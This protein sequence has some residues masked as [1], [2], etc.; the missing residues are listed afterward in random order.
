VRAFTLCIAKCDI[1][2]AHENAIVCIKMAF[3]ID[4]R[5][6]R[7]RLKH[8][9]HCCAA[10]DWSPEYRAWNDAKKRCRD[11]PLYRAKGIR[12]CDRWLYGDGD[13]TGF[14]CFVADMGAKPSPDHT[15]DRFP[16]NDGD[17]SPTNTRWATRSEQAWSHRGKTASAE[18]RA[19]QS[20]AHKG[21]KLSAETRAKISAAERRPPR[22]GKVRLVPGNPKWTLS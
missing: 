19:K 6:N 22:K 13:L 7:R 1:N 16:D 9:I 2:P 15:L 20:A 14:Q 17:Y 10:G 12:V 8:G 18:T 21:R 3:L 11:H 5:R 4:R